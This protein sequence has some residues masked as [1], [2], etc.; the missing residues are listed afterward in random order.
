MWKIRGPEPRLGTVVASSSN[1]SEG[2]A[3]VIEADQLPTILAVGLVQLIIMFRY[4]TCSAGLRGG[5]SSISPISLFK[6]SRINRFPNFLKPSL[7]FLIATAQ[8]VLDAVLDHLGGG[9]ATD[10]LESVTGNCSRLWPPNMSTRRG[11]RR[12]FAVVIGHERRGSELSG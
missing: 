12:R 5:G 8:S 3:A 1:P 4:S 10:P 7:T 11:P 2:R 9:T 6:S